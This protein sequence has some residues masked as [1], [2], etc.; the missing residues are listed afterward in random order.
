MNTDFRI[1]KITFASAIFALASSNLIAQESAKPS[2]GTPGKI[3]DVVENVKALQDYIHDAIEAK[4]AN[5]AV[6]AERAKLKELEVKKLEVVT[7]GG[8]LMAGGKFVRVQEVKPG[9]K[10]SVE[11]EYY[12]KPFDVGGG[13]PELP[14]NALTPAQK[15]EMKE[16][17]EA[18]Q[19]KEQQDKL[20][21][22]AQEA[23]KRLRDVRDAAEKAR[24]ELEDKERAAARA[25]LAA[26]QAEE[27]RVAAAQAQAAADKARADAAKVRA[28]ADKAE[29]DAQRDGA[30]VQ[31]NIA[32]ERARF[33]REGG[34]YRMPAGGSR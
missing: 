30:R 16:R 4:R 9:A 21:K 18:V 2:K 26:K 22:D 17:A 15:K 29:R 6:D 20:L 1:V 28:A 13:L 27:Q 3:S 25:K 19:W 32:A 24:Q 31:G 33:Q 10:V 14:M 11:G 34:P 8:P 12:T 5:K 7:T 23:E